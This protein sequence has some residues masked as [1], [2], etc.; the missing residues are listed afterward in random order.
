LR[1]RKPWAP[2]FPVDKPKY[3]DGFQGYK[4]TDK[5][6]KGRTDN[7]GNISGMHIENERTGAWTNEPYE[8]VGKKAT[9][10]GRESGE[11]I[12]AGC[13]SLAGILHDI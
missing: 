9:S 5:T 4:D 13:L 10:E 7:D 8:P 11:T 2:A 6:D 3:T 12:D 1:P